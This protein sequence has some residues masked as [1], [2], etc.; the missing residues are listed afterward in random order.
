MKKNYIFNKVQGA[1]NYIQNF[2][3]RYVDVLLLDERKLIWNSLTVDTKVI[4][5]NEL[6]K[7][8]MN[9]CEQLLLYDER[10]K[11]IF[12]IKYC[13]LLVHIDELEPWEEVDY[14]VFNNTLDWFIAIT[15][16]DKS[17]LYGVGC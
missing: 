2:I 11:E 4:K 10:K 13:D 12:T 6:N 14:L 9:I 3:Q 1:N 8:H 5:T 15:H 16:E 17:L 7:I